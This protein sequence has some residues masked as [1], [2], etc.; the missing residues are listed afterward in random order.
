M[1]LGRFA[2]LRTVW[3][4]FRGNGCACLLSLSSSAPPLDFVGELLVRIAP[5]KLVL[6]DRKY[7]SDN[8]SHP[9]SG[10]KRIVFLSLLAT[11]RM[12]IWTV[13]KEEILRCE[14]CSH[15]DLEPPPR[16]G[17]TLL[18]YLVNISKCCSW[19]VPASSLVMIQAD[20]PNL[21]S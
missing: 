4:W 6:I 15:Q 16:L 13:Q 2:R 11:A 1:G 19:P 10:V 20:I 8:V 3:P 5:K 14:R 12:V 21:P 17:K 18:V 9:Y 7:A